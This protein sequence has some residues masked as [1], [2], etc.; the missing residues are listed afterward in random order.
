MRAVPYGR[1]RATRVLSAVAVLLTALLS[2]CGGT[3]LPPPGTP[4]L[5]LSATNTQF[6]S[7]IVAIDSI[8]LT[9]TNGSFAA[10]L[11]TPQ[12]VDLTRV[13]DV[14]ELVEAPA[15][16]SGTY[17][18]ATITL[19]YSSA[20]IY[21]NSNGTSVPL[22]VTTPGNAIGIFT[23]AVVVTFDPAHPLVIT[24][25][26]STRVHLTLDLDS[27]NTVHVDTGSVVVQPYAVMSTP[28]LDS[29][30]LR[31]RG[32]FVY[33]QQSAFV[34]NLRPFYDLR[35]ALGALTVAVNSK[36]YYNVEGVTY[37]GAAGLAALGAVP[38]NTP[39]AAY[40]VMASLEGITPSF[41]AT[42]VI[43]G[44]SLEDPLED[45]VVGVVS[46]RS[47]N[48]LTVIHAQ[49]LASSYGNLDFLPGTLNYV[50]T[51]FVTIGPGTNVFQDGNGGTL[52]T[53]SISVGQAV[54]FGG[55]A[56]IDATATTISLD[57][58]TGAAR[59][60]NTRA[61]GVLNAPAA[62]NSMSLDLM[63]LD[64]FAA[65]A[66]NFAG[67]GGAVTAA[68]YP[69]N[70]G[71]IDES[72]TLTG[73]LLAV[74]GSVTPFGSAP[75]AFTASAITAGAATEQELV[76]EWN[77]DYVASPFS[78]INDTGLV[79]DLKNPDVG[80]YHFIYT[81]PQTLDLEMLPESPLITT[82]GADP[83][84]IVLS[85]GSTGFTTGMSVYS[86]QAT[87]VTTLY[88]TLKVNTNIIYRLVAIGH[89]NSASN[90]FVATRISVAFHEPVPTV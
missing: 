29:T 77:G 49:Y 6:A 36:T 28:P 46:A 13:V 31:A 70:T 50:T 18:S 39:I 57:T 25:G 74:D 56:T 20:L 54:D 43:A 87:F 51:A 73:T 34:M 26:Q 8:T 30:T 75:P 9:G 5:T 52:S 59:L 1:P 47:G 11:A 12:V 44:L 33:T 4:V 53:Q 62:P 10:L 89:Y 3:T 65:T 19:D 58:T 41:N 45:H 60:L 67:V 72:G 78:T 83:S 63:T 68:D 79:V 21:A 90:T 24:A 84:Q 76:V 15:V 14:G 66:F 27:F 71:S 40:G 88:N 42:T 38:I 32:I 48:S 64:G 61:W 55:T 22:T 37:V 16:P 35:S 7:Y 81:G 85:L 23:T 80:A 82:V 69:V 2:A 86:N 17:T